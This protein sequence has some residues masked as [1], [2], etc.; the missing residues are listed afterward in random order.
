MDKVS[1]IPYPQNV[2]FRSTY[3]NKISNFTIFLENVT[4]QQIEVHFHI[5]G[6][7]F[8]VLSDSVI[9]EGGSVFSLDRK[10]V[11]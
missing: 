3:E 9:I 1:I 4:H 5:N 8:F 6:D 10:S 7:S 2:T 11:V